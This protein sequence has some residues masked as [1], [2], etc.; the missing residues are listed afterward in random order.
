MRALLLVMTLCDARL[1]DARGVRAFGIFR[2]SDVHKIVASR[3]FPHAWSGCRCDELM[4]PLRCIVAV[5]EGIHIF[6]QN[7]AGQIAAFLW[8]DNVHTLYDKRRILSEMVG[9]HQATFP[10]TTPSQQLACDLPR[11][12][13]SH[14]DRVAWRLAHTEESH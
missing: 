10:R 8:D 3:A 7:D 5:G 12:G 4:V 11:H 13:I 14:A 9:W 2:Y 6:P 1:A